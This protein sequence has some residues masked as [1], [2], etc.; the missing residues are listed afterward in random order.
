M[1]EPRILLGL[2]PLA[3]APFLVFACAEPPEVASIG[4]VMRAPQG[5]LDGATQVKLSVFEADLAECA[6]STGHV[7]AI[8][9]EGTQSFNLSKD[10]CPKGLSWCKTIT[11]DKDGSTK[12][13]AVQATGPAGLLAE[14]C[15]TAKIDQDPL[16]V[17][18]Q[19]QRYTAPACCND[20]KLQAGEQCDT[21]VVAPQTCGGEPGGACLGIVPDQVCECDCRAREIALDRSVDQAANIP[22]VGTKS[23][24][25]LA[26]APG[27]TDDL[28]DGLRAVFNDTLSN[29]GDVLLR[30]LK[31]DLFAIAAPIPFASPQV[32]P[33]ICGGV[34]GTVRQQRNPALATCG[35]DSLAIVYESNEKSAGRFDITVFEVDASGCIAAAQQPV[36][37]TTTESSLSPAAA[38]G[39]GGNVLI[40]WSSE[41]GDLLARVYKP[42]GVM[43]APEFKLASGAGR[44]KIAGNTSGWTVVYSGSGAGDGDGVFMRAVSPS[45]AV[46]AEQLVNAITAGVQDQPAVAMLEDGRTLV[47]WR[48][49][50]DIYFQ[51]YDAAMTKLAG[52]QDAPL[53][54][55]RDGDQAT[56]AVAASGDVGAFF[57][58]AW[59]SA[60]GI[61]ARFV[62]ADSG[63]LY[64][65]VTG[66]NDE[67]AATH[68]DIQ[69]PRQGPAIAVGRAGFV[70]IGWEDQSVEHAGVYVRR[71][72]LP[73][74]Q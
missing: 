73:A 22:A 15:T 4:L 62:G 39:P 28:K 68:P 42:G 33:K 64:N 20:G 12:M 74:T 58:V 2:L 54:T 69:A 1:R 18:I 40:A 38:Q 8:P 51:R 52:D 21:G 55:T 43:D 53:N 17:S 46:G 37:T 30:F 66:Q 7:S 10:G 24:L 70:A 65:S 23:A 61:S 36:S 50:G 59:Q 48:S 56:P 25:A 11:L 32:V 67:F 45:G 49:G 6:A 71:F 3:A 14:G 34:G 60:G 31:K 19:L 29:Q 16:E 63:F 57:A 41:S 9:A 44:A 27:A 35:N 47:T 26:F 13:F 72:P 5:A